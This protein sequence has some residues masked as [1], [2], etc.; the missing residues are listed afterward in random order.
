MPT[1]P[2]AL[3]SL[4]AVLLVLAGILLSI[5]LPLAVKALRKASGLEGKRLESASISI[6]IKEAWMRYGGNKYL[7]VLLAGILVAIVIVYL[8]GMQFFTPRDAILAG[9]AWE[10]LLNK[11]F[12]KNQA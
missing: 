11:T 12:A 9:F 5:L 2:L 1:T 6:R 8:L 3:S 10:S 7:V 4:N